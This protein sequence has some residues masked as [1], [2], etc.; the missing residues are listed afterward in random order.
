MLWHLVFTLIAGLRIIP[1]EIKDVGHVFK[2]PPFAYLFNVLMPAVVPSLVTGSLLA[3]AAGWNTIV[4]AE[5][6][7]TYIP[8]GTAA[9]D[10][11]GIGG[12]IVKSSAQGQTLVFV[13]SLISIIIT[14]TILN[15]FVWQR[16]L[17]YAENFRFDS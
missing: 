11:L 8:G 12:L 4:V 6:L 2:A 1:R 9:Q 5:V 3:W 14:V 16:L 15:F 10:L 7:H 17:T 13:Y